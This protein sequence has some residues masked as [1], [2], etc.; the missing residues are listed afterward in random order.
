MRLSPATH[1]STRGS[2]AISITIASFTQHEERTE[3]D[4]V[5]DFKGVSADEEKGCYD[6]IFVWGIVYTRSVKELRIQT[7]GER[8]PR[9]HPFRVAYSDISANTL[10]IHIRRRL[11]TYSILP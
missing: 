2:S 11:M 3:S 8:C 10:V 1:Q 7:R 4:L 5:T 9:R 6:G